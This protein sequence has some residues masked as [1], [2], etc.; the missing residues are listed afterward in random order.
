MKHRGSAGSSPLSR[1]LYVLVLGHSQMSGGENSRGLDNQSGRQRDGH[2]LRDKEAEP[3]LPGVF[4]PEAG[5][6]LPS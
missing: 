3:A 2:S 6:M 4:L 1:L 5:P